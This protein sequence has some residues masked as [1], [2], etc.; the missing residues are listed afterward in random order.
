MISIIGM[1]NIYTYIIH[2]INDLWNHDRCMVIAPNMTMCLHGTGKVE[3]VSIGTNPKNNKIER[4]MIIKDFKI[5][6][7]WMEENIIVPVNVVI[8]QKS[9]YVFI[10][11]LEKAFKEWFEEHSKTKPFADGVA[12]RRAFIDGWAACEQYYAF[13]EED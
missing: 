6:E 1:E 4:W 12:L 2:D 3:T 9:D 8:D 11:P 10:D 5:D 7:S 13:G